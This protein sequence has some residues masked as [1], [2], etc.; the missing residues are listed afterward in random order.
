MQD[1]N[2]PSFI[3]VMKGIN[4]TINLELKLKKQEGK[5]K[6]NIKNWIEK[7]ILN[8]INERYDL[9]CKN[10]SIKLNEELY[11]K[12]VIRMIKITK[13]DIIKFLDNY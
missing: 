1:H 9:I 12:I 7:N 4:R 5:T 13:R 11:K 3:S 2:I 10:G 8:M 6:Y